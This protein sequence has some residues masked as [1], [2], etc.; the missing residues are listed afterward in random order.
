ME[1]LCYFLVRKL[2][3]NSLSIIFPVFNEQSRIKNSLNKIKRFIKFSKLKYI[4]VIFIDDGSTDNTYSIINNFILAFKNNKKIRLFLLKNSKNFGKGHSLK[5]GIL[6]ARAEWLLTSDI[7][8]SVNIDQYQKWF[9]K[10]LPEKNF[11]IYFASRRATR[12]LSS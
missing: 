5:K 8:L 9:K 7:D 4:E 6:S 12:F 10:K 11:F 3:I 1:Y 2:M